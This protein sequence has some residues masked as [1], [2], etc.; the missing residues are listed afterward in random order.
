MNLAAETR[1]FLSCSSRSVRVMVGGGEVGEGERLGGV[2]MV[3]VLLLAN[4]ADS[5]GEVWSSLRF[6]GVRE[7]QVGVGSALSRANR[8]SIEV[9]AAQSY[10][11]LMFPAM[12]ASVTRWP[13]T[14]Q[15]PNRRSLF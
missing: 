7:N 3:E 13:M 12:A 9:L 8:V 10:K 15:I 11:L 2:A 14:L 6:M 5:S 4:C 1:R